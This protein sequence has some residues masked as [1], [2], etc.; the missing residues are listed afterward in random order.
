MREN[1]TRRLW[2]QDKPA[3]GGWLSIGNTFSAEVMAAQGFDWLVV[4][5][6]HGVIG[7]DAA[8]PILQTI[9]ASTATP[10]VRV[11]WNEPS[12][13]MK[14]LDAGAYGVI[15]PLVNN[16]AQ[17]QAAVAACRYP[18]LGGRS[19]GP[20]RVSYY[21]GAD[22]FAHANEEVLCIPQIETVEAMDNLD[23][24]LCTPG[25]DACYIGPMDL[26]ISMGIT[27]EMDGEQPRY[28]EARRRIVEACRR[29]GVVPGVNSTAR[30]ARARIEE[31]FRMVLVTSDAG[32]L[33]RAAGADLRAVRG[34]DA[35]SGGGSVYQ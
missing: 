1:A 34:E 13:I 35:P 30:T 2:Q 28:V 18:P 25:V 19:Y 9:S 20:T 11:P 10:I 4:D 5:T 26:T 29:H 22:Y 27:P 31:G 8:V 6:Q 15:V 14:M 33:A 7:Y 24:I 12:I 21:A 16:R 23:D 17:A 3:L 32:S